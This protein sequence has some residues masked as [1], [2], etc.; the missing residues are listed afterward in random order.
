METPT[1]VVFAPEAIE[2]AEAEV[3]ETAEEPPTHSH[4]PVTSVETTQ[5]PV[6]TLDADFWG[7]M[8]NTKRDMD[9]AAKRL[10]YSNLVVFK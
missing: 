1:E 3:T 10:R 7:G 2:V 8:L 4:K 9:K 6:P 5:R